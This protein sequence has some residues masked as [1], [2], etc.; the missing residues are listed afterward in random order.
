MIFKRF[1]SRTALEEVLADRILS[2][3]N[4]IV[5]VKKQ[6]LVLFS[7]GSTPVGLL[8]RLAAKRF[9]W[10][11][12]IVSL[13]DDRMVVEDSSFSN[14]KMIKEL[15]FDKIAPEFQPKLLPLVVDSADFE[16]NMELIS[17]NFENIASPDLVILG[18][19]NDGHFASLFPDD[20]ASEKAL[21]E[22]NKEKLVYTRAPVYPEDR[23][24]FSWSFLKKS[25]Y[26]FL[27]ITGEE[28]LEIIQKEEIY[29]KLPAKVLLT[30]RTDQEVFWAL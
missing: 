15:F 23:I 21:N 14:Y 24:S 11:L 19:G 17:K 2:I 1:E 26:L 3:L 4:E 5:Q 10:S 18:M 8:K 6:A 29:K 28:K 22:E 9:D 7:G 12:V 30:E 25:K 27:H 20:T 16:R 13:V